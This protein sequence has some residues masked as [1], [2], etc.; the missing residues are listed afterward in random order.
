MFKLLMFGL[1][2]FFGYRLFIKPMLDPPKD[3]PP[4]DD[5]DRISPKGTRFSEKEGE[6]IDYEEVD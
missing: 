4:P 5:S 1:L 3:P 6:F 2:L